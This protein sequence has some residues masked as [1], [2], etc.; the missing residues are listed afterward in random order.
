MKAFAPPRTASICHFCRQ[1]STRQAAAPWV[2]SSRLIQQSRPVSSTSIRTQTRRRNLGSNPVSSQESRRWLASS[3]VPIEGASSAATGIPPTEPSQQDLSD[4]NARVQKLAKTVLDH[5]AVPAEEDVLKALTEFNL[6]ATRLVNTKDT[7]QKPTTSQPGKTATS[8]LLS[9]LDAPS[10]PSITRI[11]LMDALTTNAFDM[12]LYDPVFITPRILQL[13]VDLQCLLQRP[14]SFPAVFTL[15]REKPVP[16]PSSKA[17]LVTYDNPNPNKP[18]AAV[19]PA[20][21]D[22]AIDAAIASRDLSLALATIDATYCT[23]AYK[24]SK[25]LRSALF[26]LTGFLLTPPAAYTLATRFSDYQTTMDPAMATNIAMAAMMTYSVCVGSI[27]Y[28][29]LT[30]ANDQ[31]VRVTWAPGVPLWERWVREEERA[32]LDKL[33][34]AWGFASTEKWGEE[35]GEEWDYLKEFCGLR[36]MMLDRVEL[37]DGM[38]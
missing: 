8:A 21:A 3:A 4:Y 17:D 7:Q 31:M 27:G 5:P 2:S 10:M 12:L 32:A 23:T 38:E 33:S 16:R 9:N 25:F 34:Q 11:R 22:M 18:A 13:Y 37:M 30:T 1:A 24:R 14:E 36:G 35:E 15:Y 28:V 6:M 19:Q 20:V 29:A 26:P